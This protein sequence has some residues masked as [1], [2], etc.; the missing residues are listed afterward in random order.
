ME[1]ANAGHPPPV[2][3]PVDGPPRLLAAED[4]DVPLCVDPRRPRVT[5]RHPVGPGETLLLYTDGLVEVPGEHLN[6][7]LARLCRTAAAARHRPL[8][9]FCDHL[10]AQVADVRDDIAVIAFRP[11]PQGRAVDG[12]SRGPGREG[13]R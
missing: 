8:A 11:D 7:G 6:D 5:H 4:A 3:V 13:G 12:A 10:V 9:D 1:W 2:L